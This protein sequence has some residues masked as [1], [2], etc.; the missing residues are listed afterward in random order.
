MAVVSPL[1]VP[2]L[3]ARRYLADATAVELTRD[4][5]AVASGLAA[6]APAQKAPPPPGGPWLEHR[7][8]V[9][10]RGS[11]GGERLL[12]GAAAP[13]PPLAKRLARLVRQGA[14]A[15]WLEALPEDAPAKPAGTPFRELPLRRKA[16]ALASLLIIGPVVLLCAYL[17]LLIVATVVGLGVGG[18][19]FFA[20]VAMMLVERLL[21]PSP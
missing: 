17:T 16:L 20:A 21:I 5:D 3:R 15:E 4:P 11:K 13:H 18:S 7:F 1:V 12:T 10:R 2:V 6:L 19:V 14:G 8:V 9:G